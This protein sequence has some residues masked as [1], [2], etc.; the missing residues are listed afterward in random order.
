MPLLLLAFSLI[1]GILAQL[2]S[3][4]MWGWGDS[5]GPMVYNL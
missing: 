4:F 2:P 3:T 5:V 1:P